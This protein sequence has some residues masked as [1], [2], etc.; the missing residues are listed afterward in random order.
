LGAAK[1]EAE[2]RQQ[3]SLARSSLNSFRLAKG[4]LGQLSVVE[5][6]T[7]VRFI[8][9]AQGAKPQAAAKLSNE[10]FGLGQGVG[11]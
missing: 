6:P 8:F 1:R 4:W 11:S 10:Q 7:H 2:G 5:P 3:Q 9:L